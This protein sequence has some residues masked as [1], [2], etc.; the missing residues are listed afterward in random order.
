MGDRDFR[1]GESGLFQKPAKT[2]GKRKEEKKEPNVSAEFHVNHY[3]L[4]SQCKGASS[5]CQLLS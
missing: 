5:P 4:T 2:R 3:L 1:E